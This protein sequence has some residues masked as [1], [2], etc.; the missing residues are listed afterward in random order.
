MIAKH[1]FDLSRRHIGA[2]PSDDLA[3]SALE[4]PVTITSTLEQIGGLE[5]AVGC[6]SRR[7]RLGL[8]EILLQHSRASRPQLSGVSLANL[9][10][11]CVDQLCLNARH[12]AAT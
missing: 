6:E 11:L 5:P 12:D 9:P 10:A 7:C 8:Q 2:A 3:G 4:V 1:P